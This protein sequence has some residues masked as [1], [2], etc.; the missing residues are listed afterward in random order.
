MKAL[1]LLIFITILSTF[2]GFAQNKGYE[3][4]G[5]SVIFTFNIKD[6]EGYTN[7][8]SGK[9]ITPKDLNIDNVSLTGEFN[10]WSR[11]GWKMTRLSESQFRLA[12]S[13]ND[14]N[15]RMNWQFKYLVNS[16]FWAEPDTT[17]DNITMS[18]K[19]S[20]WKNVYNLSLHTIAPDPKGNTTFHLNGYQDA[21]QVILAGS[22]NKWNTE[23]LKMKKTADGWAITLQLSPGTHSY[24][25]IVDGNWIHDPANPEKTLN[26]YGG[27]NSVLSISSPTTFILKGHK[28]ASEVFLAGTFNDWNPTTIPMKRKGDQWEICMKLEGGKHHYK[29]VIDGNWITDPE[30]DIREYDT[31]G[32]LNSVIMIK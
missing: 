22:F 16:T 28:E 10:D 20:F 27:L 17:F 18:E 7:D 24:K 31:H 9:R 26:E 5:D 8:V 21:T 29:F 25:F 11:E 30:N 2:N 1:K 6:Y 19:S 14:L 4:V 3:I 15:E 12:K 13:L 23:A 32:H